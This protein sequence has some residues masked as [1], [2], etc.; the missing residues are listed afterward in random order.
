[1]NCDPGPLPQIAV[2][3]VTLAVTALVLRRLGL[4]MLASQASTRTPRFWWMLA[5]FMGP[6]GIA[7]SVLFCDGLFL[8][9]ALVV[10]VAGFGIWLGEWFLSRR[11]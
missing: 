6:L 10:L 2:A 11:R 8:Q 5:A 3:I 7:N 4:S 1:V 9:L